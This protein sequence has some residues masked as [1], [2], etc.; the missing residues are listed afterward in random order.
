VQRC[1]VARFSQHSIVMMQNG[2]GPGG[3]VV[4]IRLAVVNGVLAVSMVTSGALAGAFGVRPVLAACGLLTI[5][6]GLAGLA[7]RPIRE[8]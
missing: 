1:D 6:A 8:A 3:R 7:V 2:P 4:A 5:A